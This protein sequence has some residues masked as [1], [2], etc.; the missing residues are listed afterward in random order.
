L[1]KLLALAPK[2]TLHREQVMD[3]L[4][5]ELTVAGAAPRL[6]KAA[7]F[8]RRALD[9]SDAVVL[10]AECVSL[11]PDGDV[12]VDAVAFES[13]ALQDDERAL[14][15]YRGPL[16]PT[17]LY[18]SWLESHRARL[19]RAHLDLLRRAGRWTEVV[20][21]DPTDEAAHVALMHEHLER[22]DR[23]AALRQFA[24][25]ED[26]LRD[27]LDAEPTATALAMRDRA[28]DAEQRSNHV[29]GGRS[30]TQT[31]RFCRADDGT[32]LAWAEVGDGP[33]LVK[34]ATW[35]THLEY[36]WESIVWR[37]WLHSLGARYRL[38][39]YDE[40]GSGLSDWDTD[41][42]SLDA[43]VRDLE[44]VVDAAGLDRFP[45]LG[46]SQ[47]GAVAI[48]YAARHPER[49]SRL[50]IYGSFVH[51]PV[52]RARSEEE[53]RAAILLGDLAE[54]GWGSDDPAFRQVFTAR[55]M[56]EGTQEQWHAFN[57]LQRRTTS[58][59]NAARYV[60]VVGAVDV[61]DAATRVRAPTLVLHA[62][63]DLL[64]P[65]AQGREVAARVPDSRFVS[66]ESCNHLLLEHE[67]AWAQFLD[68]V[69][70]FLAE[71]E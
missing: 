6:H 39:R 67:P 19:A 57:E 25:L 30:L 43:W 42:Y 69:E 50:V 10:D 65:L 20:A 5:P 71:D 21:T 13:L 24:Q 44:T 47:G 3:A 59:Q 63:G 7:H 29:R 11:L 2:R 16:L 54:L 53:R 61:E 66:L 48:E 4:W 58:P 31:I 9:R 56:P 14:E 68:E 38:I 1:V 35:L 52:R 64:P 12:V 62:R 40:R 45:L 55:F 41:E 23:A 15:L 8:V 32:Q 26:A 22:G 28:L 60:R 70:R 37:H 27:E 17:D 46:I 49:V 51:G 33:P 36:D 34:S 18:D